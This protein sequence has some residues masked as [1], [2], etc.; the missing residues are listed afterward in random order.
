[1]SAG[2]CM[3]GWLVTP[4]CIF[5]RQELPDVCLCPTIFLILQGFKKIFTAFYG[6]VAGY[7]IELD[8]L[9]LPWSA[10]FMVFTVTHMCLEGA[11]V[12]NYVV[13][14]RFIY[15]MRNLVN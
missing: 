7:L 8:G 5:A 9:V 2:N 13:G 1:M 12:F 11:G 10:V 6:F 3:L 4:L 15:C 14:P